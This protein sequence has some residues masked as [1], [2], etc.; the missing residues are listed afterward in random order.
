MAR[1]TFPCCV[2]ISFVS[3]N[4]LVPDLLWI[5][6]NYFHAEYI[7]SEWASLPSDWVYR[8]V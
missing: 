4:I 2:H 1:D 5:Q 7:Y 3:T 6:F 8:S